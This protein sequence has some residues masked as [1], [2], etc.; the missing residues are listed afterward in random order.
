M[1]ATKPLQVHSTCAD[2]TDGAEADVEDMFD[3]EFYAEPIN[4]ESTSQLKGKVAAAML[5]ANDPRTLRAIE[6]W[7]A[8]NP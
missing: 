3:R 7:L 8:A 4:S 5:N 1:T 6:A 2:F